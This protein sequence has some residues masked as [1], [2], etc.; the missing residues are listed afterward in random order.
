MKNSIYNLQKSYELS[1]Q[2][3]SDA[4]NPLKIAAL[5]EQANVSYGLIGGHMLSFF[6]GMPRATIDVDFI[7]AKKHFSK[8]AQFIEKNFPDLEPNDKVFHLT[9]DSKKAEKGAERID[10]VS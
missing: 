6:T 5:F 3:V 2:Q 7:I 10:L 4:V 8:A 1:N 9:F